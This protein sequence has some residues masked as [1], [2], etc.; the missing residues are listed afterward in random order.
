MLRRLALGG[1]FG[2]VVM[3]VWVAVSWLTLPWHNATL[4]KFSDEVAVAAIITENAQRSGVYLLPNPQKFA[5][6]AGEAEQLRHFDE[7]SARMKQGPLV[8][9]SVKREG[10]NLDNPVPF[11]LSLATRV[12]AALLMTGLVLL[13]ARPGYWQRVAFVTSLGVLMGLM[14][15]FP[16]WNWWKFDP[17]FTLVNFVDYVIQALLAGMVIAGIAGEPAEAD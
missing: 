12:I 13:C 16:C 14:A 6:E 9:A 3:F 7:A 11:I 8:F 1:F 4:L 2:G 10:A 15:V 17:V 5:P